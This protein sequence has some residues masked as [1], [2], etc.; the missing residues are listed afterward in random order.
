MGNG[1]P[2]GA[3]GRSDR[4]A[5]F[6]D[7][8]PVSR[9]FYV[10]MVVPIRPLVLKIFRIRV[11]NREIVPYNKPAIVLC[12]HVALFDP[13]WLYAAVRG[14][15]HFVTT[16][17]IFRRPVL[18]L[19]LHLYGAFPKRKAVQDFSSVK[20]IIRVLRNGRP[21]AVFPEGIR[22]WDGL[23]API[24]PGVATLIQKMKVPVIACRQEGAYVSHPRWA[25]RWRRYPVTFT[26]KKLYDPPMIP[27]DTERILSDIRE[28]IGVN[29]Y[30]LPVDEAR[31]R[32]GGLAVDVTRLLYRCPVCRTYEGLKVVR[33]HGTNRIECAS[34][35]SSWRLTVSN[36]LIPLDESLRALDERIPLHAVYRQIRE[37]PLVP[38]ASSSLLRLQPGETL[39]LRSRPHFLRREDVF[40]RIRNLSIGRLYLTD[41]R[42]IFRNRYR[43]ILDAPLAE[44]KGLSTEA[45]NRFNFVFRGKVYNVMFRYESILKWFDTIS[46]LSGAGV[47]ETV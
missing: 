34:C 43:L 42:V 15:I 35:S 18:G 23:L 25:R 29:D 6:Q 30:S 36:H 5:R 40:P 14:S 39:Y 32:R 41:R 38:Q 28:A 46:R 19:L 37:L 1:S 27:Q 33:P 24:P 26:F 16:E 10:L 8:K 17:D 11:V 45:G 3:N 20:N 31:Y 12:N 2:S 9:L 13:I 7:V 47:A 4:L 22:T 44:I 21:I